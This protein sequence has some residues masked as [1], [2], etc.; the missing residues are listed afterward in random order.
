MGSLLLLPE[1]VLGKI[2]I[3]V[4][5]STPVCIYALHDLLGTKIL[6]IG[7]GLLR[8]EKEID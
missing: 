7:R 6:T 3:T 1:T 8:T 2:C 4:S 5:I